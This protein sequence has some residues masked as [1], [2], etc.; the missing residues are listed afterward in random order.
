MPSPRSGS[1]ADGFPSSAD[2]DT[3]GVDKSVFPFFLGMG[4][5]Q[6]S[7]DGVILELRV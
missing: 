7:A 4:P 2:W 3:R 6:E 5:Q 1:A